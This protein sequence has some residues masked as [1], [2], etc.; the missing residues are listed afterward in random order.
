[1]HR[2]VYRIGPL[3]S[4][5]AEP[6]AAVLAS[7]PTAV[8]SHHAAAALHGIAK[9]WPGPVDVTVTAGHR[10]PSGVSLHRSPLAPEERTQCDGIPLTTAARTLVDV[11]PAWSRR[12]LER[13]VEQAVILGLTTEAELYATAE[14]RKRGAARLRC[15]LT[16]FATPSLTRSEAERRLIELIRKAQLPHPIANAGIGR[17]EVD[18]LWPGQQ[19]VVEVDGFAFHSSRQAF[20][21]D[22]ARDAALQVA[23]YRVIRFTWRQIVREPYAVAA[24]LAAVLHPR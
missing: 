17:Y 3:T 1:M 5:L 19:L 2:G 15:V 18:L 21:R 24:T 23:G 22:R 10:R 13:G 12:E 8:L 20:E 4:V 7:G 14:G 11:A 16:D 9:P 6:F